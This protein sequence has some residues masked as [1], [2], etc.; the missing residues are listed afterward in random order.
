MG[1][2]LK[3]G[4]AINLAWLVRL[5]WFA[6][7]GQLSVVG[8]VGWGM[9]VSLRWPIL[10]GIIG[11][12]ATTN[13][14]WSR[15]LSQGVRISEVAVAAILG[16]DI[17]VLTSLLLFSGGT[18]NPFN[19]LY[20]VYIA[21]AAV[22]LRPALTWGLTVL[23]VVLFGGLFLLEDFVP[24]GAHHGHSSPLGHGP[25]HDMELHVQGMWVAFTFAAFFIVYFVLR[26]TRALA[27]R[28]AEL[29]AERRRA[30][31][32]QNLASLATL[33]AGATHE[34]STPL[35]T[36]AVVTADLEAALGDIGS[37]E[38]TDDLRL[39]HQEVRR[40]RDILDQLSDDSGAAR[41][42]LP[43]DVAPR[44]LVEAALAARK[45]P[46][47]VETTFSGTMKKLELPLRPMVQAL[48]GLI[49][50]ACDA[51]PAGEA[52]RVAVRGGEE[53]LAIDVVDSGSGMDA[54]TQR[55]AVEPFFSTKPTGR[56]MG[57]GLFLAQ[58]TV[59]QHG[60]QLDLDST[61]GRGTRARMWIPWATPV[62]VSRERAA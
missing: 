12:A 26:I 19:F 20:L 40:C 7:L 27:S 37:K 13:L 57:L 22:M 11:V 42:E 18:A 15:W 49:D 2:D 45:Q 23:S 25:G 24:G 47:P 41:G 61:P 43:Q 16:F 28:D 9:G 30:E 54:D 31:R 32:S 10:V 46:H 52:V 44:T 8:V 33:A 48:R 6:A 1:T 51:S 55:R 17:V 50:N 14:L 21:L 4:H 34:L 3:R 62:G 58:V 39:I 59:E 56:G 35:S 29:S 38:V 5:R 53:G 36:I 60:G